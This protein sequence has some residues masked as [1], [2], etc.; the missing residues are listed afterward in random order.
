VTKTKSFATL[1]P[2]GPLHPQGPGRDGDA[3]RQAEAGTKTTPIFLIFFK[4]V[5]LLFYWF[6]TDS[7]TL[8]ITYITVSIGIKCYYARRT[9]FY[10]V[11]LSFVLSHRLLFNFEHS[12]AFYLM[13]GTL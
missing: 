11:M 10:S 8:S 6:I 7:T 1:Q 9:H 2:G 4:K 12:L 3:L 13:N 5:I